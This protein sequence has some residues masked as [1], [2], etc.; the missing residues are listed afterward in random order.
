MTSSQRNMSFACS[1][2]K[3]IL[4]AR[5]PD[6]RQIRITQRMIVGSRLDGVRIAVKVPTHDGETV[7][8]DQ[9]MYRLH[10]RLISHTIDGNGLLDCASQYQRMFTRI[11]Q[12]LQKSQQ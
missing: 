4:R 11:E 2:I 12:L 3:K 1:R 10:V 7:V 6:E 5:F 9:G 8:H